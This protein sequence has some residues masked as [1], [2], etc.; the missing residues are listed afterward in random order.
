MTIKRY[1]AETIC[2]H[3]EGCLVSYGDHLACIAPMQSRIAEL[4]AEI[5]TRKESD[6]VLS[7]YITT[8]EAEIANLKHDIERHIT[9]ASEL[10]ND[11][12]AVRA[13]VIESDAVR[14]LIA[15]LMGEEGEFPDRPEK[16]EGKPHPLYWW[17]TEL[18]QRWE[19]I[20]PSA[21]GGIDQ[22]EKA[23]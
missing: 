5:V 18:R 11:A 10:A 7:D 6:C 20:T 16:V 4:E 22:P 12:E 3:D 8:Q 2:K 13:K 19:A 21:D 23:E 14:G 1:D 17:R 15:W 9:I